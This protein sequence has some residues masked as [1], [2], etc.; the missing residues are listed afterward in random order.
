[1]LRLGHRAEAN[2][3]FEAEETRFER[4]LE[5]LRAAT[6]DADSVAASIGA[7]PEEYRSVIRNFKAMCG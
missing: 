1:M 7:D 3:G 4:F 5:A 2:R 6:A